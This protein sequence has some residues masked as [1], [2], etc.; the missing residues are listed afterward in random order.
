MRAARRRQSAEPQTITSLIGELYT[1][2]PFPRVTALHRVEPVHFHLN[3]MNYQ[4]GRRREDALRPDSRIWV[5]GCGTEQSILT[6]L[7]F[8]EATILATDLSPRSLEVS[9]RLA[10]QLGIKNVEF[11]HQNLL[12]STFR[13]DFDI[14]FCTGVLPVLEDPLK[15]MRLLRQALRSGG[16]GLIMAYNEQHRH[17]FRQFQ[18]AVETLAGGPRNLKRKHELAMQLLRAVRASDK[19]GGMAQTLR[20]LGNVEDDIPTF[21]DTL[22]QPYEI[23]YDIDSLY[24]LVTD[25][26][27]RL[28][29]PTPHVWDLARYVDDPALLA[30]WRKLDAREQQRVVNLLAAERAPFFGF[31]VEHADRPA[32]KPYSKAE[33]RGMRL[34][35]RTRHTVY[36]IQDERVVAT[37]ESRPYQRSRDR[38][39]EP[40]LLRR[41]TPTRNETWVLPADVEPVLEACDGTR[42]AGKIAAAFADRYSS[43]EVMTLLSQLLSPRIG[44]L[45]PVFQ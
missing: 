1:Q 9:K 26:G 15:G 18:R 4:L 29:W 35:H 16:A 21:A 32:P 6:A 30:A 2:Y 41:L 22:L 44:L 31:Y 43:E 33:L 3:R 14:I 25:A 40:P 19:C 24:A 12:E 5:A 36:E 11:Q 23:A 7:R 37:H 8:P 39:V 10:G 45:A 28:S 38:L 34:M 17:F 20:M 13:D 42:T 27:L